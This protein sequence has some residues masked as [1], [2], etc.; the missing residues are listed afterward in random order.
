VEELEIEPEFMPPLKL[1]DVNTPKGSSSNWPIHERQSDV[2][3]NAVALL[4]PRKFERPPEIIGLD[5]DD[6]IE[7]RGL[8]G[9]AAK[10][11]QISHQ[12]FVNLKYPAVLAVVGHLE[13]EFASV[14][15]VDRMRAMA[16]SVAGWAVTRRVAR[17]LVFSLSKRAAGWPAE[18]VKRAQSPE[19]LS[20][21]ADDWSTVLE[22]AHRRMEHELGNDWRPV[23]DESAVGPLFS[24]NAA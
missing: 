4:P 24:A 3:L 18:D 6:L 15:N 23:V 8:K 19:S 9:R 1:T 2:A 17:A 13:T 20:L 5:S 16:K 14:G 21:I 10:F 12:L 11:Y 22:A 7:E